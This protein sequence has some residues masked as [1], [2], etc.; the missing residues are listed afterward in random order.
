MVFFFHRV[1]KGWRWWFDVKCEI[2]DTKQTSRSRRRRSRNEKN[3]T[4]NKWNVVFF[5]GSSQPN[6]SAYFVKLMVL[7]AC[8]HS[9]FFLIFRCRFLHIN[10]SKSFTHLLQTLPKGNNLWITFK[11]C[12]YF[13]FAFT[14]CNVCVSV[15]AFRDYKFLYIFF[16]CK[17]RTKQN[18]KK[19]HEWIANEKLIRSFFHFSQTIPFCCVLV[20]FHRAYTCVCVH[21]YFV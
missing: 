6:S 19:L 18:E 8:I 5:S 15:L 21:K 11:I 3:A 14:V 13:F 4:L 7:W 20:S 16:L 17:G 10:I 2:W 9:I 12:Y 1:F